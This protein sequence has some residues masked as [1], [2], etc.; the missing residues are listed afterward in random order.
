M[1]RT[2]T[3]WI[4]AAAAGEIPEGGVKGVTVLGEAVALFRLEGEFYAT[5]DVCT[6]ESA[7]LS[8]GWVEDGEVI[9]P[10]HGARFGIRDGVCSGPLGRDLR[11]YRVRERAGRIEV[12]VP[13]TA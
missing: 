5:S 3:C 7:L 10:L 1:T 12:G 9:C 4:D 2:S 13:G 8:E 6:H 11:C